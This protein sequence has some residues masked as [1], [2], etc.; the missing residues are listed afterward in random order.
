MKIAV[1]VLSAALSAAAARSLFVSGPLNN[2]T[3]FFS[4]LAAGAALY[5]WFF[6][7]LKKMR[8][9]T[10]SIVS[11]LASVAAFSAFLAV[12]GSRATAD[13]A[14]DFVIVLGAGSRDGRPMPALERRLA[15]AAEYHRRNPAALVIVSGGQGF[16]ETEPESQVMKRFLV[17]AG[18]PAEQILLESNS[19]STFTNMLYSGEIIEALGGGGAP[20][21]A[22]VTNSFHMFRS[23]SFARQMGFDARSHPA[24]TPFGAVWLMYPREVAAVVKMWLVGR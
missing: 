5:G 17:E 22:V 16:G 4:G 6:D 7:K 9:L 24:P 18:V 3:L 8:W 2:T 15:A 13:F 12:S 23:I 1:L 20:S 14:E 21:V 11:M 19:F 10:V